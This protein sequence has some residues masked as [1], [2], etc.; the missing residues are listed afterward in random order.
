[1]CRGRFFKVQIRLNKVSPNSRTETE[2][3]DCVK[4]PKKSATYKPRREDPMVS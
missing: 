1:M 3:K 4:T 2:R